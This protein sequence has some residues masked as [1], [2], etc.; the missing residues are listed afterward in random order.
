MGALRMPEYGTR[1]FFIVNTRRR[2]VAHTPSGSKNA[3]GLVDIQQKIKHLKRQAI[4][5]S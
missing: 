1:F 2:A 5:L 4:N 3:S